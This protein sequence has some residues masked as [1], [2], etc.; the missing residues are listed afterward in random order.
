MARVL[1]EFPAR[2]TQGRYPWDVWLDG[3]IRELAPGVDF[4]AKIPTL[5]ANA[6]I[7]AK[8]RGGRVKTLLVRDGDEERL[9]IQYRQD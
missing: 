5:K 1:K 6:Q 8:K 3:Q 9:V 4:T 2:K 7:Q